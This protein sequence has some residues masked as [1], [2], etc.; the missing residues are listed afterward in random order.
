MQS[1]QRV[2]VHPMMNKMS[3]TNGIS[4]IT[5]SEVVDHF[6]SLIEEFHR[7][8][9][10]VL[11]PCWTRHLLKIFRMNEIKMKVFKKSFWMWFMIQLSKGF[12]WR[13]KLGKILG[14]DGESISSCRKTTNI[15]DCCIPLYLSL[16]VSIFKCCCSYNKSTKQ[17]V[18]SGLRFAL[19][20]IQNRTPY[21][22]DCR[23]T[24]AKSH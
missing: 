4:S 20:Y 6:N 11:S 8:F 7:C 17:T 5:Q 1:G 9:L 14:H 3:E 15:V 18:G 16:W 13:W 21:F 19:R 2:A 12:L 24:R 10:R 22:I 23:R